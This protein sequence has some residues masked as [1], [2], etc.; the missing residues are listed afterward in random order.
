VQSDLAATL[1]YM[2]DQ[3]NSR[4]GNRREGLD[5]AYNAFYRGDIATRIC[6]YHRENGG[7]LTRDDMA[8]YRVRYEEPLKVRFAGTDI[9][10]CG[11]WS[12]GISLAQAFTML[13][14]I[15][16]VTISIV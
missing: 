9:Y 6:E 2:V 4:A 12:Q 7:L 5:A 11:P 16:C 8:E 10:C 13:N 14:D 3:E 1:Q 15:D